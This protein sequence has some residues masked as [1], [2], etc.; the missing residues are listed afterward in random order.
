MHQRDKSRERHILRLVTIAILLTACANSSH[1][2]LLPRE[3]ADEQERRFDEALE[4]GQSDPFVEESREDIA[5]RNVWFAFQRSYPFDVVP[6]GLHRHAIRQMNLVRDRMDVAAAKS[7]TSLFSANQ[8]SEIGPLNV[9]GRVR[10][11]ALHPTNSETMYAGAVL[12]GVWKTTDGGSTWRTTFDKQ[13]S[14][15]VGAIAVDP[16]NPDNVYVGTGEMRVGSDIGFMADG[17]FKSTDAGETWKNVGLNS[18]SSISMIHVNKRNPNI[19][20]VA[21]GRLHFAQRYEGGGLGTGEGFYRST[22]AGGTWTKVVQGSVIEMAV[23]PANSD[24]LII[25]TSRAVSR[26]EDAGATFTTVNSGIQNLSGTVRMSLAY[27][28]LT[29]TTLYVLQAFIA[30]GGKSHAANLYKSTNGGDSWSLLRT[31]DS[32]FFAFQ[33]DYDNCIAIDPNN[34]DNIVVGG[35]DLWRSIDGGIEFTNITNTRGSTF[36]SEISHPDQHVIVFDRARPGVMYVGS[37]GGVYKSTNSGE[38]LVRLHSKLAITQFHTVEVDQ[39]RPYRVYGGTQDNNTQGG[40]SSPTAYTKTWTRLLGGD[41]FWVVVDNTNPNIIYAEY[42]Y[43]RLHRIDMTDLES[44]PIDISGSIASDGG[45]WS[46]PAAISSVDGRLYSARS[47]VYRTS[48]P[49]GDVTWEALTPG[50][51]NA[52]RKAVA[53]SLSPFHGEWIIVGNDVGDVR[54]TV[55]DGAMWLKSQGLPARFTTD[56]AYD[57]VEQKRIYATFSGFRTGHVYVSNDSGATFRN[58]S[59]NLPDVPVNTIEIDPQDNRRLFIG[60]DIGVYVSLDGGE[61]WFPFSERFPV[62]PVADMKIHRSRRVLIAATHGRSMFDVSIDNVTIPAMLIAPIGGEVFATPGQMSVRWGGFSG[63]VN[64]SISYRAGD[65]FVVVAS[66]VSGT[67][68][69]LQLPA[70]RSTT[71]RV[72][73]ESVA[74]GQIATSGDLTLNA[75]SNIETIGNRGF[76]AEAIAVRKNELW[77]TGRNDDT[78]RRLSLPGLARVGSAIRSGVAGRVRDL[79]YDAQSDVFY[80]LTTND[81]FSSPRVYRLDTNGAAIA[82]ITLPASVLTASGIDVAPTGLAIASPGANGAIVIIDA[83]SGAV[84]STTPYDDVSGDWRRG[85][86]WNGRT[87]MQGVVRSDA[88]LDFPSEIQQLFA[89]DSARLFES[90]TVIASSGRPVMFYDLAVDNR[91][92]TAA[93]FY[94]TDTAGVIYRFLGAQFSGVEY[95]ASATHVNSSRIESVAPNPLGDEGRIIVS[96]KSAVDVEIVLMSATGERMS[97]LFSGRLEIGTHERRIDVRAVAAGVHYLVMTTSSGERMVAPV[98]VMR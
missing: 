65:P 46:A 76:I 23:N 88:G 21:A 25:S 19:I 49:R 54:F 67:S 39:T 22:D 26:S 41:G 62:V 40:L 30:A 36:D 44:P 17:M 8:W 95:S 74:G 69:S 75:T 70:L 90:I 18:L 85:L 38:S 42:Q 9:G 60:T 94:A 48:T 32:R 81:D 64:V 50:Y 1:A 2:Q 56:L 72:R 5:G 55:N 84:V 47:K 78:I 68:T 89:T 3:D 33:G 15:A 11:I 53:L 6:A 63:P 86:I 83:N 31:L 28:Q 66:G 82:T 24:E 14:L 45:A 91:M 10:S 92:S 52:T 16:N 61:A 59:A 37:D 58:I 12:G 51:S 13:S 29:P 77:A 87:Y 4:R 43:G 71:A 80:A 73:V 27:D 57:P 35:V 98:V 20:Y 79:A 7:G 93:V 34:S 96:A 97:H